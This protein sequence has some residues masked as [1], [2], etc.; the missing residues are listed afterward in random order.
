MKSLAKVSCLALMAAAVLGGTAQAQTLRG[1]H[2]YL[3]F[4]DKHVAQF[5]QR[6]AEDAKARDAWTKTRAD[7]DA[8]LAKKPANDRELNAALMDL[9]LTYRMTGERKYAD[10]AKALLEVYAGRAN[11]VTDKPLLARSPVWNSDLGMGTSAYAYGLTY[12]AIYDALTPAERD[13]LAQ[14]LV[15]G[16]I[17]PILG[18]WI[19]GANRIHSLDTMGHNWFSHI[20]F[21]AGVAAIAIKTDA[22]EADAW[23]RRIDEAAEEWANYDGSAIET[24]PQHFAANGAFVESINYADFAAEGY[25]RFRRAWLDAFKEKPSP[26][27]RLAGL[28]DYFI[29][30]VYP[31]D[32][33]ALSTNFGDGNP[34]ASGASAIAELWAAGDQPARNLWYLDTVR[35]NPNQ[36]VFA[37]PENLVQWPS[38]KARAAAANGPGLPTSWIDRDLGA[39]TLRSSWAP[40]ATFLALRSGFTWNH[41]H[42][43]AGSFILWHKGKQLLI[44]SG[45]SS[46]ARPEYDGYYRQSVAH[47][48]VTLNGQAEPSSNTYNGSHFVGRVDHLVDAGDLRFVWADATGPNART[49]ERKYRSFLWIGDMILVIDDL[50]G[51]EPGQFEWLLHY[52]GEAKRQGQVITVRNGEAE[53]AVRP[54]FPQ[55]LPDGGLFTDYPELMR[56]AEGKGLKDH[57]PDEAQPYLR[58]Q[59]PGVTDRTKF[60]VALTPNGG[61]SAPRIERVETKDY[62]LVRLY[63]KGEVTEVYFNLL[64]DGR[65][66]HRNANATLGGWETDAYILVLTYP[67]G[68]DARKPRRWFV[69]D[70]SYLRR[71]GKVA[72]DSLSKAF[73]VKASTGQGVE[74]SIQ[75]Q[76]T[77]AVRL[78]CDGARSIKVD[79]V[80]KACEHDVALAR[81]SLPPG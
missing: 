76:S 73:V 44:D 7:A 32:A 9:S 5:K 3:T 66:R 21:G 80:A 56:M 64:A 63:Q 39:A 36:D 34:T 40:N 46:Y 75:G 22:P 53:V 59:A 61:A 77:Y 30:N 71:D 28:A 20:V 29:Q 47:N 52:E 23:V 51:W 15:K 35:P 38:A 48:V 70:G 11:W 27:P 12:D 50:K 69:A 43:D 81:R 37:E 55:T 78:A 10:R 33:G 72:L 6:V 8:V 62:L 26:T 16:A 17:K 4:S 25:L 2:P 14:G 68:G 49:F 18:D 54:L 79:G 1:G 19:D 45:N 67:E 60:V 41:N 31:T 57:A 74:A 13:R 65:I 42:A 24:K 58:L